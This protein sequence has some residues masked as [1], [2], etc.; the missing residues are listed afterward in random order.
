MNSRASAGKSPPSD[1]HPLAKTIAPSKHGV[2]RRWVKGRALQPSS[3]AVA[4]PQGMKDRGLLLLPADAIEEVGINLPM[5][6]ESGHHEGPD[7][8][9]LLVMLSRT[10]TASPTSILG[11]RALQWP[12][13]CIGINT[14]L[15]TNL[16]CD[17]DGDGLNVWVPDQASLHDLRSQVTPPTHPCTEV[18][19]FAVDGPRMANVLDGPGRS[20]LSGDP[21]HAVGMNRLASLDPKAGAYVTGF[22]SGPSANS[23]RGLLSGTM[24]F[25]P[26]ELCSGEAKPSVVREKFALQR[27]IQAQAGAG[28]RLMRLALSPPATDGHGP[29]LWVGGKLGYVAPAPRRC[30][31]GTLLGFVVGSTY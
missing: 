10:P 29:A 26:T 13:R 25:I 4:I 18:A 28:T 20:L 2:L 19:Q 15:I 3:R 23:C 31:P 14:E 17:D 30:L 5:A 27:D 7:E 8:S 22:T 9:R 1:M 12:G 6:D 11:V 21:S 24:C 16:Q